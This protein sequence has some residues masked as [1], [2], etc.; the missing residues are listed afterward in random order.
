MAPS[1]TNTVLQNLR[2]SSPPILVLGTVLYYAFAASALAFFLYYVIGS[3][4]TRFRVRIPN[5]P[6]PRGLPIVGSLPWLR[7]K[8]NAEQYRIWSK[9]YGDVFQV[10]LGERTVVVVNGADAAR[11][12][13]LGQREATKSRP[14]FYVLH[15][16]V[17]GGSPTTSIG[18]SPWSESC[19]QRRKVAATAMNRSAV[20]SYVPII[21]SESRNL[22]KDLLDATLRSTDGSVD[23]RDPVRKYVMNMVL[24]LNYGTRVEDVKQLRGNTVFAEMAFVETEISRLRNT[25]GN[26]EN[27]VPLLRPVKAVISWLG[28]GNDKYAAEIG[29][30][31]V[32]YHK[33]LLDNLRAEVASGTDKPCIQGNVLKDPESKGLTEGELLSVSLSMMAGSDSSQPVVAWALMVLAHRPDIQ[34]KA[35]AALV[36]ADS[37]I[38]S[39]PDVSNSKVDYIDGFTKELGRFYTP[40][41]LGLPRATS[42]DVPAKWRGATIP[43]KTFLFLNSWACSRDERV[44]ANPDEFLPE[45][46]LE[47]KTTHLHQFAFGMGS[48]MC[49]ANILAHKALYTAFVHIIA[50][51]EVL[52]AP[53][54]EKPKVFPT[55]GFDSL[56]SDTLFEEEELPDY[57]ADRFLPVDLG[58][59]LR[60]RYQICAKLG[61]GS[62]STTWLARDLRDRNH[63]ALKIYVHTSEKLR[64]IPVYE[65]IMARIAETRHTGRSRVRLLYDNFT[66]PCG[67]HPVLVFQ[68]AQMSMRDFRTVFFKKGFEEDFVRSAVS[69]LLR[70]VDFLHTECQVIHTDIHPG[71]LLLGVYDKGKDLFEQL[72]AAEFDDPVPRKIVSPERTIYL[73]RAM[74]PRAGPLLL[75]DFGEA[76]LDAR[77]HGGDIMPREYRAPEVLAHIAWT[78][79]VD[80]WSVALTAWDLL[81]PQRLFTARDGDGNICDASH[82]AQIIAAIGD[83]PLHF[84]KRNQKYTI[85]FWD[86]DGT[87]TGIVPIPVERTLEVALG[88]KLRDPARFLSFMRRILRWNPEE[89]PSANELL[90]DPWLTNN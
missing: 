26:Y 13:F 80:I 73:S 65:R 56:P 63:V 71:N 53:S 83:A 89:R 31:R 41:K 24:T 64:E 7:G 88:D 6:G 4:I 40:L 74:R 29:R 21:N 87:W 22:L 48:R 16:K 5:L 3:E 25:A 15:R 66:A 30:R 2:G 20:E 28:Y 85:D 42:D 82:L 90:S 39:A 17:Q 9:K 70:A 44:F 38:L 37:G 47:E 18:T 62:S 23:V 58:Q 61:F 67:Q 76:R 46:W 50:H 11:E 54:P 45:R 57:R 51:F 33:V 12:L 49:I 78:F 68:P 60:D 14:I 69:E 34:E 27:Y 55:S 84:K 36:K 52:P 43:T 72:E 86:E 59:V 1:F 19:K 32:G 35:F 79:P 77:L 81:M 75:A 10:Q 8:V